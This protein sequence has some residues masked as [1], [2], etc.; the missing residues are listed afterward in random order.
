M[1]DK[2]KISLP[3]GSWPSNITAERVAGKTPK[4]AE[5]CIDNNR[6]F[7]LQT[8]PE[9][10]GRVA[11]MMKPL[12][13]N[14]SGEARCILPRP[15][16]AKSKVHEYGG[17]S[18]CVDGNMLY[19]VL[20]DDQ[21][22]YCADVTRSDF[23][24]EVLSSNNTAFSNDSDSQLRFADLSLDESGAK[25]LAVCEQHFHD[26]KQEPETRLVAIHTNGSGTIDVIAE[27]NNFYSNPTLSPCG[28]TL[29]WLSWNHPNMPWDSTQLWLCHRNDEGHFVQASAVCVAGDTGNESIFQPRFSPTGDLIFVSD[30]NNW[31]NL[32][33]ITKE[34]FCEGVFTAERITHLNAEFATPQWTFN[35]STYAFLNEHSILAT[36]TQNGA[37]QLATIDT[38]SSPYSLKKIN[39][40]HLNLTVIH[41]IECS[42]NNAVFIAAG[43]TFAANVYHYCDGTTNAI[44]QNEELVAPA[45]C[46]IPKAVQF[47][48]GK[49][50]TQTA[51]GFYYPPANAHYFCTEGKPPLIVIC[52]GGPTGATEN[53][54][55]LKIQYWTNRGFAVMDVNYRGSTG[56]GRTFRHDLH[57]NWGI[58]DVEDVCAA[59]NYAVEQGWA[60]ADK[61]II[62]GSS[63][64]GYTVLAA[65][66]FSSTFS[67]GVSLYG[68]G[69]LETL[70]C[71]THKF[72][73]RYLDKLVGDYNHQRERYRQ[74]SPIHFV[75]NINCPLLVFQGLE[76][77]VVPPNQAEAMVKAVK[78]KGLKVNYVTFED[79]GHGFRN[80]HNINTMLNEELRF[81]Q[82]VFNL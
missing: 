63:A 62:K 43:P 81:Y 64:G 28:N 19:F 12:V 76:D 1:N 49:S 44:I 67:A 75:N 36:Y 52:H 53:A 8:L 65:L 55:N 66:T 42:E 23:Q 79:E 73:A 29:C 21:Q 37:W 71:D 17:G 27:G 10:K 78:A 24:P 80:A 69:N 16:S 77:K 47:S 35:M 25:L 20:A 34:N 48:T 7:W 59:A 33:R 51:Y 22:V 5:P 72:E 58:Y 38:R 30:R 31:W 54:L 74:R 26:R 56:F 18:Y 15:L 4:L 82:Q 11:V 14:H 13:N 45:E 61:L 39:A 60:A 70:V 41:G 2:S 68:I 46:S 9:E 40:A 50:A 57:N 32:Y 3:F 6:L